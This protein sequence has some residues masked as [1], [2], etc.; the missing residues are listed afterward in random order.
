MASIDRE[1]NDFVDSHLSEETKRQLREEQL[2][3]EAMKYPKT[4]SSTTYDDLDKKY[5]KYKLKYLKLKEKLML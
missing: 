5:L 2:R 3:K 1:I 4:A